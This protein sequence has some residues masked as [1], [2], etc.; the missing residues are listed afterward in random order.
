M[1]ARS[2]AQTKET[3]EFQKLRAQL[4]D[5]E[6]RMDNLYKIVNEHGQLIPFQRNDAQR[7]YDKSAWFR[8]VLPKSRRLG[9]STHIGISMLDRMLF[10]PNTTFGFFDLTLDDAQNNIKTLMTSY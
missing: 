8:N 10:V 5:R 2:A 4:L 3:P 1:A 6:W 9:F 7:A